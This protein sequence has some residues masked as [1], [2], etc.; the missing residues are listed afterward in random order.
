MNP[1]GPI[2]GSS[3]ASKSNYSISPDGRGVARLFIPN[4]SS[5]VLSEIDID[6]VLNSTSHG[7][8]IRFDSN[9]TGSGS[10]D[11]QS[12]PLT[13]TALTASPY[14][15]SFSGGDLNNAPLSMAG[16]F[17]LDSSGTI[18]SGVADLNADG[19][20]S[21]QLALSGSVTLG[22]GT[23]P[24]Q[25]T[26]TTSS[27]TFGFSVY[28]IDATHLKFIENDGRDI[29]VGDA[30]DQPT[31]TMPAGTLVLSMTGLDAKNPPDLIGIAGLMTS[32][33]SG[34]I[35]NGLED[36]NDG[37]VVDNNTNPAQPFAFT[38]TF[39]PTGGGRFEVTLSNYVGGSVFAAYPS[40]AG[41]LMLEMDNVAG[42]VTA[43]VA[44]LQQAGATV[45]VSQG[46]G[47]NLTGEDLGT[48]FGASE[49]DV[50][51]EFKTTNT[52]MNGLADQNNGGSSIGTVN[53]TG[54]YN[55]SNGLGSATFSSGLPNIFFYP[56]DSSTAFFVT[57][58]STVAG[59]GSFS[60]QNPGASA[61]A[62]SSIRRSSAI[63]VQHVLPHVRSGNHRTPAN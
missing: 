21:A 24:G 4:G 51:A 3:L 11:L 46:Y 26:L 36:V 56:V 37:G 13:P 35:T 30:F 31:T 45:S 60:L 7:L 40:S 22:T 52:A 62:Q 19:V 15:F 53:L 9:G 49:L 38:G 28:A 6:F 27:G 2:T 42:G 25:A 44:V 39:I 32:D 55:I 41:L 16:A 1:S 63:P 8:V 47:L 17:T 29:L 23:A 54:T 5:V 33:G 50:V 61:A 10:I 20:S 58:D 12:A 34:L 57:A 43:G 59:V 14:A 48:G 18:T